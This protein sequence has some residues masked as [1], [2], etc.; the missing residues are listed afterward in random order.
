MRSATILLVEDEPA[1]LEG[2]QDLL[3]VANIGYDLHVVATKDGRAG[4]EALEMVTPD[5]IISDIMMP[6]VDGFEFLS[7]VRQRAAWVHIPFIFL[8]ARGAKE[9]RLAGRKLGAELY[10]TKPF[11]SESLLELVQTQLTRSFALREARQTELATLQKNI[12]QLLNHE[13]RTP[14]TYVTAYFEMLAEALRDLSETDNL[15]DYLRGIQ[16]GCVRLSQLVDDLIY[17]M[18]L[19]TGEAKRQFAQQA[20]VISNVG[21]IVL[22]TGEAYKSRAVEAGIAFEIKIANQLPSVFGV[23]E[24]LHEVLSRL[25][26]NAIK[27]TQLKSSDIKTVRLSANLRDDFV[28]LSVQDTGIGIPKEYQAQ[29]F[30]LFYQHDRRLHEQQGAGTG[31]TIVKGLVDLHKGQVSVHSEGGVGSRFEVRLPVYKA[32]DSDPAGQNALSFAQEVTILLVEDDRQLLSSLRQLLQLYDGSYSLKIY[33]ALN[34]EDGLTI[35]RKHTADLIISDVMMPIMDGY[36]FLARVRQE[37]QWL[38]IPFIFL[39]AKGEKIDIQQGLRSGA[40]EYLSKPFEVDEL[41]DSVEIQLNRSFQKRLV[42]ESH[43]ENLKRSILSLLQ[44]DFHTPLATVTQQSE[45]LAQGLDRAK[46]DEDLTTS[47]H[48]IRDASRMLTKLVEDFIGMAELKTGEAEAIYAARVQP[49]GYAEIHRILRELSMLSDADVLL[50]DTLIDFEVPLDI[51]Q[52]YADYD[53]VLSSL[54]RLIYVSLRFRQNASSG[55]RLVAHPQDDE[56]YLSV[57]VIQSSLSLAEAKA[58]QAF[59]DEESADLFNVPEYGS[60]LSVVKGQALL[61]QGRLGIDNDGKRVRVSL[62]LSAYEEPS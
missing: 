4:L 28:C 7:I 30:S 14:L 23:P 48:D 43:F 56:V 18:E 16:V 17:V 60:S 52:I 37:P 57:I 62:I 51:P 42:T 20:R 29:I 6:Y 55:L 24:D 2:I 32:E 25:I 9:D 58:I 5:L 34:G 59:F 41:L 19:R 50:D 12:L 36:E 61:H 49:L 40:E 39:T 45:K 38:H 53:G 8:T 27:F 11:A 22:Q 10:L 31:L 44:S 15:Q 26:D 33:T 21:Q 35:L 3:Q 46:T 54:R 13:F 47:L 1:I